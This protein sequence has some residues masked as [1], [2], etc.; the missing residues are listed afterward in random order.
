ARMGPT[1]V[2]CLTA[3]VIGVGVDHFAGTGDVFL[4]LVVLISGLLFFIAGLLSFSVRYLRR[5]QWCIAPVL[6]EPGR[7]RPRRG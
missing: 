4:K 3:L 6:R 1:T 7:P 2:V 5:P